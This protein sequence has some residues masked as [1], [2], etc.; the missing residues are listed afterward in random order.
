LAIVDFL[1]LFALINRSSFGYSAL[2]TKIISL[3]D[4][5]TTMIN[6]GRTLAAFMIAVAFPFLLAKVGFARSSL[7]TRPVYYV[8]QNGLIQ[9]QVTNLSKALHLPPDSLSFS[10]GVVSYEK[11]NESVIPTKPVTDPAVLEKLKAMSKTESPIASIT[12][13]AIDFDAI[14]KRSEPLDFDRALQLASAAFSTAGLHLQQADAVLSHSTFKASYQDAYGKLVSISKNLDTKVNF[15]FRSKDGIRFVGPGAQVG[16]TYNPE[17]QVIQVHYAWRNLKEGPAVNI[18]SETEARNKIAKFLPAGAKIN[19]K[20]V[21][22]CPPIESLSNKAPEEVIPWYSFTGTVETKDPT[23]GHIES[24]I[25]REQLIPATRGK[26]LHVTLDATGGAQVKATATVSGGSGPYR[27]VWTGSNP[28]ILRDDTCHDDQCH[29]SYTPLASKLTPYQD[30]KA[31]QSETVTVIVFDKNWEYSNIGFKTVPVQ[32]QTDSPNSANVS[33][34]EPSYGCESPGEYGSLSFDR[35][36][37][38]IGMRGPGGGRAAFCWIRNE[39]WPGDYIN[40]SSPS[41]V[42]AEP[43]IY[44]DGNYANWG[45]NTANLVLIIGDGTIDNFTAMFPGA[46][47]C[48]YNNAVFLWRPGNKN[49]TVQLPK[50]TYH[51][52]YTKSWGPHGPNR[53]LYWLAGLLCDCLDDTEDHDKLDAWHRWGTAFDGLHMLLG[54]QKIVANDNGQFT[55]TF[56]ENILGSETPKRCPMTILQAWLNAGD[57]SGA[58]PVGMGPINC[59]NVSDI[60]DFYFGKGMQNVSIPAGEIKGW[61]YCNSKGQS[62]TKP[63]P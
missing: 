25:T 6:V 53:R 30:A 19:M 51:V 22:W 35:A 1:S 28:T 36:G 8:I 15:E 62:T 3:T 43:W 5:V 47:S 44:G 52:D 63:Y 29:I 61:W 7:T 33:D 26:A 42:P 41:S 16:I 34:K 45:I 31:N 56:A 60:G 2:A 24:T 17:G 38:Q 4:R 49:G 39:S 23:T 40:S 46:K 48:D 59:D 58:T 9:A 10:N 13:D 57:S 11:P 54:F 18:I 27:Y 20:L 50:C 55:R 12:Y 21:Y 37:W 32:V 14:S